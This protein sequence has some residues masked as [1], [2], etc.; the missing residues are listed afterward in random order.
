MHLWE[1]EALEKAAG[2]R[3]ELP[4]EANRGP[5]IDTLAPESSISGRPEEL[6]GYPAD[7]R[8]P[9]EKGSSDP[10]EEM[11]E[12]FPTSGEE[13]GATYEHTRAPS[14]DLQLSAGEEL[15]AEP[16]VVQGSAESPELEG[17][18][19]IGTTPADNRGSTGEDVPEEMEEPVL[20]R[21]TADGCP[22]QGTGVS[23][24]PDEELPKDPGGDEP[25]KLEES[26]YELV[27]VPQVVRRRPT[28]YEPEVPWWVPL[29]FAGGMV[30]LGAAAMKWGTPTPRGAPASGATF[31]PGT[32]PIAGP[33]VPPAERAPMGHVGGTASNPGSEGYGVELQDRRFW[34]LPPRLR[35]MVRTGQIAL[36]AIILGGVGT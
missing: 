33:Y 9:S 12:N 27:E 35:E 21:R 17:A 4:D 16:G 14:M 20:S 29:A 1:A 25:A 31:V 32:A 10:S 26:E 34:A 15:T 30:L 8:N 13:P 5:S 6:A 7:T 11:P 2:K 24:D 19:L 23:A 28:T 22:Q 36:D 3:V 18:A